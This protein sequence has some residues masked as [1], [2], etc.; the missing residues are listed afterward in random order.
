MRRTRRNLL[1]AKKSYIVKPIR[2]IK[3][4]GPEKVPLRPDIVGRLTRGRD[5]ARL[6]VEQVLVPPHDRRE[7]VRRGRKEI[8]YTY[9]GD[10]RV[11]R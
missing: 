8:L 6:S 2:R 4:K 11:Q 7:R 9:D 3:A 10:V 5:P 1:R